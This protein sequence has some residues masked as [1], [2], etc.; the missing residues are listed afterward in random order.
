MDTQESEGE[1]R[2]KKQQRIEGE[3]GHFFLNIRGPP[4]R[5]RSGRQGWFPR[6]GVGDRERRCLWPTLRFV[7]DSTDDKSPKRGGGNGKEGDPT[8]NPTARSKATS[9]RG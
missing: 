5:S 1:K 8:S 6:R 2:T 4:K 3:T 7:D 9:P